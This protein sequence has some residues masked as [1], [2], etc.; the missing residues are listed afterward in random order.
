MFSPV[1]V[2][3]LQLE[4]AVPRG[5]IGLFH[6]ALVVLDSLQVP[7]FYEQSDSYV[8]LCTCL[9]TCKFGTTVWPCMLLIL[10]KVLL[11]THICNFIQ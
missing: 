10:R 4:F 1:H 9:Q 8:V 2:D 5:C 11:L 3:N 7:R 6:A